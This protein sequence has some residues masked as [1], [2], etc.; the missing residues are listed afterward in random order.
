LQIQKV[1]GNIKEA[2]VS[3]PDKEVFDHD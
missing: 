1:H 2:I 3:K